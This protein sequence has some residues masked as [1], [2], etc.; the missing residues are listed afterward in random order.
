MDY[1]LNDQDR[2][3]L[4]TNFIKKYGPWVVLI[5]VLIGIGFGVNSYLNNRKATENQN[6]SIAYQ[7]MLMATQHGAT[8]QQIT[9]S[10]NNLIQN[11]SGTVYASF[12]NLTLASIAIQETNL[13]KAEGILS[14]TLKQNKDTSLTPI[15]QM[16][17]AR[18]LI[19]D[20]KYTD[21]INFLTKPP[22]GFEAPFALLTG[23]AYLAQNNTA[24]ARASYLAAENANHNA[25]QNDPLIAQLLAERLNSLGGNS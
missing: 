14:D 1:E 5:V 24:A 13:T 25:A 18:V 3:D 19:A 16:R 17:L 11:Y 12:A 23:D 21:A 4:V 9:D 10:A 2:A 6:A 20:H 8:S 7:A 22:K 15:I